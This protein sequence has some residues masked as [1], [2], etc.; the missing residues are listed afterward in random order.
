MPAL[1]L[2][3]VFFGYQSLY[4]G[5]TQVQGY[6]Y[7]FLDLMVPSKWATVS[8]NPPPNDKAQKNPKPTS[9]AVAGNLLSNIVGL[10]SASGTLPGTKPNGKAAGNSLTNVLGDLQ[11]TLFGL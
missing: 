10:V 8:A 2:G 5:I 11:K 3:I 9:V 6:N 7:G 4:Y 1:G